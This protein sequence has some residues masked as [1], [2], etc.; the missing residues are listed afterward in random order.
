MAINATA[1]ARGIQMGV[2]PVTG[3]GGCWFPPSLGVK[4][5]IQRPFLGLSAKP[6]LIIHGSLGLDMGKSWTVS[7]IEGFMRKD[8]FRVEKDSMGEMRVPADALY[9]AQ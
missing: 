4:L 9:G 5:L 6:F 7:T 3:L 8:T 1:N 2:L